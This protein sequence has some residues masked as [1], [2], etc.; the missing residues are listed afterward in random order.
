MAEKIAAEL[1]PFC[2]RL[3]IAGSIRR[4]RPF[5]GDI[6]LVALPRANKF[7]ALRERMLRQSVPVTDGEQTIVVRLANGVQ[8]DLWIAQPEQRDLLETKPTNFGS[9]LLCRTGSREHNIF[10]IETAKKLGLRWNPYYGVFDGRGHCLASVE[11]ADLFRAL[12]LDFIPP[13]LRERK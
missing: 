4:Q 8:V 3:E 7:H 10:M 13:E 2:E 12:K 11:E 6:D 9:L 1:Q 5:V